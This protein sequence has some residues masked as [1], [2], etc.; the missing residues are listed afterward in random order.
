MKKYIEGLPESEPE[1]QLRV[2]LLNKETAFFEWIF[3][4]NIV[5]FQMDDYGISDIRD[6]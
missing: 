5:K 1:P 2:T 3:G 4:K 6:F